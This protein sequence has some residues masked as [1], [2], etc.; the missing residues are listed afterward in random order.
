MQESSVALVLAA[1]VVLHQQVIVQ[2]VATAK[3]LDLMRGWHLQH[4][5]AHDL[6]VELS[7]EG[8]R[9]REGIPG[10]TAFIRHEELVQLRRDLV[11]RVLVEVGDQARDL[12]QVVPRQVADL[13]G[14]QQSRTV[15]QVQHVPKGVLRLW[16]YDREGVEQGCVGGGVWLRDDAV[17]LV[18][19]QRERGQHEV[20]CLRLVGLVE[21]HHVHTE[22]ILGM[23]RH[24]REPGRRVRMAHE[25]PLLLSRDAL[26]RR[27]EAVLR[28]Y[29]D[30]A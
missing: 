21:A 10:L 16:R 11:L 29:R 19:I 5:Q 20:Q 22:H 1:L 7:D 13:R 27:L 12:R 24:V 2:V 23:L 17:V 3:H 4:D 26:Q 14:A 18:R 8:V 6:L 9:V 15:D 30:R 28:Q 25:E